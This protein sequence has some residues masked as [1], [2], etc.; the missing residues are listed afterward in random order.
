MGNGDHRR[1]FALKAATKGAQVSF[2]PSFS[3]AAEAGLQLGD[4]VLSFNGTS[5]AG[6]SQSQLVEIVASNRQNIDQDML[7]FAADGTQQHIKFQL[8][9]LRWFVERRAAESQ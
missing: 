6:K 5:L 4:I 8:K 7:V 1:F 2:L 3:P 9:D